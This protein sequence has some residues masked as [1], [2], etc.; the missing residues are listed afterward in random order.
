M[1]IYGLGLLLTLG[2]L[3]L[4]ARTVYQPQMIPFM[5]T[6]ATDFTVVSITNPCKNAVD[7][8]I[9]VYKAD[10]ASY[11]TDT[12]QLRPYGQWK[13]R[14]DGTGDTAFLSG[15]VEESG[16]KHCTVDVESELNELDGEQLHS[17]TN[18]GTQLSGV[19][20]RPSRYA[21]AVLPGGGALFMAIN[22]SNEPQTISFCDH[23]VTAEEPC[24]HWNDY[25]MAPH[26]LIQA[27]INPTVS[28]PY[29]VMSDGI[30]A[31]VIRIETGRTKTFSADSMITF[32]AGE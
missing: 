22:Y 5:A 17:L 32:R 24:P 18:V 12:E 27:P 2:A 3:S 26:Q 23:L 30:G 7:V 21:T 1:R 15:T 11:L 4:S 20:L 14:F 13:H 31:G 6:G 16:P 19:L 9:H 10:G 29:M 25:L 8:V 28:Y